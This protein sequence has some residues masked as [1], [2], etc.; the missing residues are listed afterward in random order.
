MVKFTLPYGKTKGLTINLPEDSTIHVAEIQP[1]N[2]K[3]ADDPVTLLAGSTRKT[4]R[5]REAP[6]RNP[7]R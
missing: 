6:R 3:L 2:V 5:E 7:E 4:D 1:K